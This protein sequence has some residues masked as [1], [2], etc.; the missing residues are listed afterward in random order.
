VRHR[1]N[2]DLGLGSVRAVEGRVVVVAFAGDVLMRLGTAA[3][4][5][6]PGAAEE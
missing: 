3:D 4:V 1:Y 2:P 6:V 5:L